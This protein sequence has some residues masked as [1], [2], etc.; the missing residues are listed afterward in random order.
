MTVSVGAVNEVRSSV[1][2]TESALN[3]S[4]VVIK[5]CSH[6]FP[7]LAPPGGRAS[8]LGA[9]GRGAPGVGG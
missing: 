5:K 2:D 6:S 1:P 3:V 4:A 9:G 7:V 8:R